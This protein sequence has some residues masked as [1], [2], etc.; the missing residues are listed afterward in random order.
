MERFVTYDKAAEMLGLS[1]E[2]IRLYV[3]RGILTQGDIFGSRK[4][5]AVFS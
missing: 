1:R 2:S 3:R 5:V 4:G